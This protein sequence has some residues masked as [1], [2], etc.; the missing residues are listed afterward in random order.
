MTSLTEQIEQT[1][2]HDAELERCST[3]GDS[4]Q[5]HFRDIALEWGKEEYY[6]A[7]V[8]LSGVQKIRRFDEPVAQLTLE[9]DGSDVLQFRK[10]EG[11]AVLLIEW[12]HFQQRVHERAHV[13]AQYEIDYAACSITVEKQDGLSD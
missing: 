6:S 11:R 2:F 5:L 4:L 8:T 10:G 3:E 1:L 12:H 9:G 7:L 13:F